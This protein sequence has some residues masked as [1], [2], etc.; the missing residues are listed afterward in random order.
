MFVT[1]PDGEQVQGRSSTVGT[2]CQ[3]HHGHSERVTSRLLEAP[4][5]G[6]SVK[7]RCL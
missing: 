1:D 2:G 7:Q 4:Q 5:S 3:Q 6:D